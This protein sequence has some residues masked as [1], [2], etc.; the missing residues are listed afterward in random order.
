MDDP[1]LILE[2]FQRLLRPQRT[3]RTMEEFWTIAIE[4]GRGFG[5][6]TSGQ[7]FHFR[8]YR[9]TSGH[10]QNDVGVL[11]SREGGQREG[12]GRVQL[13]ISEFGQ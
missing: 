8:R 9:D 6:W 5:S 12:Q 10:G 7:D 1:N 11:Q 2:C 4:P 13:F 3:E